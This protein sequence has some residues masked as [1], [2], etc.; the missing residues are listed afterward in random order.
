MATAKHKIKKM[1]FNPANQRLVDFLDGLEKLAKEALGT[2]AHDIVGQFI[3]A[4]TP[5]HLKKSK[6]R[7]HSESGTYE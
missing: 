7:A 5:P 3:Y 2:A 1:V 6:N 4:K